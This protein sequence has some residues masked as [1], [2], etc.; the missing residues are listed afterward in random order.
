[1]NRKTIIYY[2]TSRALAN[3]SLGLVTVFGTLSIFQI[4][5][6]SLVHALAP[7]ALIHLLHGLLVPLTADFIGRVG[8]RTSI[9][10]GS[11][12]MLAGQ[13]PL[14]LLASDNYAPVL[15]YIA[16][17]AIG[18]PLM[19]TPVLYYVARLTDARKRGSEYGLIRAIILVS[20]VIYPALGGIVS[21]S[22]GVAGL[23][24]A[25]AMFALL[26]IVPLFAIETFRFRYT[27]KVFKLLTHK[28]FRR[29]STLAIM[30][31][32]IDQF[33][34]LWVVYVFLLL[35]SSYQDF[36]YLFTAI[37]IISVGLS[38]L[39]GRFLDKHNRRTFLRRD[40]LLLFFS[41]IMRTL[42]TSAP[43][44]FVSDIVYKL[45]ANLKDSAY[46]VLTYDLM[47]AKKHRDAQLDEHIVVREMV[48][49]IA[50]A[51]AI[52]FGAVIVLNFGFEA[53]FLFAALI[54]L[55]FLFV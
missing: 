15:V 49:N 25:S 37:L 9:I 18:R 23:I 4:F 45:N 54:S 41:W 26:S 27:G 50:A 39:I 55:F 21:A 44:V 3:V 12:L 31:Q 28:A 42:A 10:I 16:L 53:A 52:M 20:I 32:P 17:N 22:F 48:T 8:T 2:S 33:E 35:G 19:F 1:M 34:H 24:T 7:L 47:T 38:L 36:G 29:A 13:L 11:V 6:N 46:I 30:N 14:M 40:S 51:V 43:G 5:N